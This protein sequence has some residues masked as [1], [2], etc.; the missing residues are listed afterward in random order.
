MVVLTD[1][2]YEWLTKRY[3][4]QQRTRR[5][6]ANV[7]RRQ[8]WTELRN[9]EK[10]RDHWKG[11]WMGWTDGVPSTILFL[12]AQRRQRS[13]ARRLHHRYLPLVSFNPLSL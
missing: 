9:E 3:R 12:S 1:S 13:S 6:L 4:P 11:R 5:R 10:V 7:G 2:T 8:Q